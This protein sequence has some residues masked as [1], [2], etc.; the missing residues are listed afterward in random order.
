MK[1]LVAVLLS[2]VLM[3]GNACAQ[4]APLKQKARDL[5]G[6]MTERHNAAAEGAPPPGLPPKSGAGQPVPPPGTAPGA[7]PAAAAAPIKP[8]SQ[9]QAA[10]KLKADIAEARAKGEATAEMKKQ[11]V[12]DLS[13]AVQG[14]SRPSAAAL[15]KFGESL[16]TPLAV[17][18]ATPPDDTKLVKAIVVSLNCAG[19][20]AA[21]LQEINDEVQTVLTK[22]GVSSAAASL[23]GQNL[24]A[25][26]AD[27]QSGAAK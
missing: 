21:R 18:N 15:D 12:Q 6:K 1:T 22:S 19:L 17:K 10:T 8:S 14:S 9:Q 2:G 20:S 3:V 23:V 5:P 13:S 4:Y 27:I 24:G 16:L 11:F 7:P 26:V 25:V